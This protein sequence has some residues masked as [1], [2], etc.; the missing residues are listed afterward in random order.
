MNPLSSSQ[1]F[2]HVPLYPSPISCG[3]FGVAD[4]FTEN[5]LSLDEKYLMN[6][7][8]TF[9]LRAAGESMQPEIKPGDILVVDRSRALFHGCIAT[10]YFNSHAICKQYLKIPSGILL[11]SLNPQHK[12]IHLK[13][14]DELHLFGVVIGLVRDL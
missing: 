6:K 14:D 7:E 13:E 12:D 9:F 8:A 3:L 11:H 4:D 5:Y 2:V 10:F 1:E